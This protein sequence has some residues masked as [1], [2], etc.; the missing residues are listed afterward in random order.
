[1][2]S[3]STAS[4]IAALFAALVRLSM[5][6]TL[7]FALTSWDRN[8]SNSLKENKIFLSYITSRAIA[9]ELCL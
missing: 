8:A 2:F 6:V 3:L 5:A 9:K 4:S 7:F 1:V